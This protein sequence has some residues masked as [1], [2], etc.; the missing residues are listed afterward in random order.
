[1]C[2]P[3]AP[4][5]NGVVRCSAWTS[6]VPSVARTRSVWPP[7]IAFHGDADPFVRFQGRDFFGRDVGLPSVPARIARLA[8]L[9]GCDPDPHASRPQPRVRLLTW[10]CPEGMAAELYQVIGGGHA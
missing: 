3:V 1:M 9:S 7:L 10:R 6:P 5:G 8:V 2:H 4:L